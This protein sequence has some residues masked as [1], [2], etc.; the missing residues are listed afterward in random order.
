MFDKN[1]NGYGG[2]YIREN[3]E[4]RSECH[5]EH[6]MTYENHDDEQHPYDE[7]NELEGKFYGMLMSGEHILW[8]GKC[9]KGAGLKARGVN[10]LILL[11]PIFWLSFACLWTLLASLGGGFFGLFGIPFIIIGV[12]MIKKALFHGNSS[13]AIT[14]RRIMENNGNNISAETLDNIVNITVFADGNNKGYI[15]YSVKGN[16]YQP[17]G[18]NNLP[19]IAYKGFFGINDPNRVYRILSDAV[20]SYTSKN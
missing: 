5:D 15:K 12:A 10:G 14:N 17:N 6:G 13:Y 11:F 20:Y 18:A 3:E 16:A 19:G 1:E 7:Y 4:Y 9:E 8:T 2:D